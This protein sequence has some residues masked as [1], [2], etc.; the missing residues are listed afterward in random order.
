ML[1]QFAELYMK[2]VDGTTT[3]FQQEK[4]GMSSIS[5]PCIQLMIVG[6]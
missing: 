2:M 6:P 1:V 5:M 3:M 4:T